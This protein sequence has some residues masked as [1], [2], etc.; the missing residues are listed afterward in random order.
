MCCRVWAANVVRHYGT[1]WGELPSGLFSM[2]I[3]FIAVSAT[4]NTLLGYLRF[5]LLHSRWGRGEHRHKTCRRTT[6]E[7]SYG[8]AGARR[9]SLMCPGA[10]VIGNSPTKESP[11]RQVHVRQRQP[12][13][14]KL[15]RSSF[16]WS[17]AA[18]S[19]N[20]QKSGKRCR[21]PEPLIT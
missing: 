4:D 13:A 9:T 17:L 20:G 10:D 8:C 15:S 12:G 11:F 5:L 19:R 18:A 1:G 14:E 2:G 3:F 16:P 21:P 6:R 7:G